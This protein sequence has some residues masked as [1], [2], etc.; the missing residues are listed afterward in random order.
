MLKKPYLSSA[1]SNLALVKGLN[2][3]KIAFKKNIFNNNLLNFAN[4]VQGNVIGNSIARLKYYNE[5]KKTAKKKLINNKIGES[6][7]RSRYFPHAK[8]ALYHLR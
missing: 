3:L 8:R 5:I 6:G 7:Y 4:M 1:T 2:D